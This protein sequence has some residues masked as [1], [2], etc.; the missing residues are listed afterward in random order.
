[1]NYTAPS[2][3]NMNWF[4]SIL[5]IEFTWKKKK[6]TRDLKKCYQREKAYKIDFKMEVNNNKTESGEWGLQS[7]YWKNE[8]QGWSRKAI[9]LSLLIWSCTSR[10]VES[11]GKKT[12]AN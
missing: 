6:C 11:N 4:P 3:A 12:I 9:T 1:M 10:G 8:E 2:W 7:I 5:T